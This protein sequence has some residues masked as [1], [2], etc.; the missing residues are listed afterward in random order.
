VSGKTPAKSPTGQPSPG[1]WTIVRGGAD[2]PE[3][4]AVT[5]CFDPPVTVSVGVA[6]YPEDGQTAESLF[7]AADHRLYKMKGQGGGQVGLPV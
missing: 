1:I 3:S 4:V 2:E 6:V 5:V 7:A